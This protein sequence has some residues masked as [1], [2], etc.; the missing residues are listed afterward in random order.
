MQRKRKSKYGKV[1]EKWKT[2]I[3]EIGTGFSKAVLT[4]YAKTIS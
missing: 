2:N 1:T 3:K 4:N